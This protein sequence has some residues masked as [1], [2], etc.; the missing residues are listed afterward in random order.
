[1]NDARAS[2]EAVVSLVERMVSADGGAVRV[3]SFDPAASRLVVDYFKGRNDR[4]ETC[5]LDDESLR[6]FLLESLET[7]GVRLAE[8][9]VEPATG[10]V[11]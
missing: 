7:H 4:C 5:V 11:G 6:D 1:M 10:A 8:V 3:R 9:V 2:V